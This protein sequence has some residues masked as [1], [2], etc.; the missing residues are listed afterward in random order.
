MTCVKGSAIF[1][2]DEEADLGTSMLSACGL[3]F[4][5]F[6]F[7]EK[8]LTRENF[9]KNYDI[10]LKMVMNRSFRRAPYFVFAYFTLITGARMSGKLRR[11]ILEVADERHEKGHWVDDNIFFKRNVYLK[12]FREKVLIHRQGRELHPALFKFK[13]EEFM[14]LKVLVGKNHF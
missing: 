2:D 3:D 4:S 12:D 5:E 13:G 14:D 11:E 10:L 9:E 8:I 7:N 1:E 6:I